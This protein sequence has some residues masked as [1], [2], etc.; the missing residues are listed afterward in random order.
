[1]NNNIKVQIV[2]VTYN[3]KNYIKD[4]LNSFLMQK[5]NFKFEV[6]VG[7]DC[8]NDGTTE[9]IVEYAKE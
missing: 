6:L 4:A 7:D 8:S 2:C 3:Q 5:T 1:M 9:I